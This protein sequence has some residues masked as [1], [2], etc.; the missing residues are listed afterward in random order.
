MTALFYVCFVHTGGG[1]VQKCSPVHL[2][3]HKFSQVFQKW[4]HIA[5]FPLGCW[6]GGGGGLDGPWGSCYFQHEQRASEEAL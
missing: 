5:V 4:Y 3:Q 6:L 2:S 1:G